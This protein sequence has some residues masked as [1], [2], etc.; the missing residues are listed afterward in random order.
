MTQLTWLAGARGPVPAHRFLLWSRAAP[1]LI[2]TQTFLGVMFQRWGFFFQSLSQGFS[3]KCVKQPSCLGFGCSEWSLYHHHRGK[4]KQNLVK[5]VT[6]VS[7]KCES[8]FLWRYLLVQIVRGHNTYGYVHL[9]DSRTKN[10]KK[11]WVGRNNSKLS[12]KPVCT[13]L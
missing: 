7:Q 11:D 5:S 9:E 1:G 2:P 12:W 6:V 10:K 13:T 8:S 3:V 4:E